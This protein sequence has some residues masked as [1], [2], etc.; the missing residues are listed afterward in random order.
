MIPLDRLERLLRWVRRLLRFAFCLGKSAVNANLLLVDVV[1]G[2]EM[3]MERLR[4]RPMPAPYHVETWGGGFM[5]R[6]SGG[7]D[8]V[9]PDSS[10]LQAAYV[11]HA[12]A[13]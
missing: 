7:D 3:D 12:E 9:R 6:S 4:C 8:F 2:L 1:T 10:P 5:L 11:D 13:R